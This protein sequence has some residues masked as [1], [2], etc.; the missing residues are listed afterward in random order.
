MNERLAA[1]LAKWRSTM[2]VQE[3]R[4]KV[5]SEF[6]RIFSPDRIGEI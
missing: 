3:Y 1:A 5:A 4:R 6:Y 2:T